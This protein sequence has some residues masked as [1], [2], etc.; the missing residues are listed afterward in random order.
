M[1]YIYLLC[2]CFVSVKTQ[3]NEIYYCDN[4]T[5]ILGALAPIHEGED[6]NEKGGNHVKCS[7]SIKEHAVPRVEAMLFAIDEINKDTNLLKDVKLGIHIVDTC[8]IPS[9]G[10]NRA[11]QFID[12]KCED[13]LRTEKAYVAGVVGAMYSSVSI[14]VA[15]FLTPWKLPQISPA[16]TSAKLED[17]Y[18]FPMF[19][20]T[21]PSDVHQNRVILDILKGLDW[22]LIS[23]IVSNEFTGEGLKKFKHR[24]HERGI[25]DFK[26][27]ELPVEHW[28]NKYLPGKDDTY[29]TKIICQILLHTD[30]NVVVFLTNDQDTI[31]ILKAKH[32]VQSGM[33]KISW[34][35]I[36]F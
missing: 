25:C 4:C 8:G 26:D 32:Q 18:G 19:A 16:S 17:K 2:L 22:T 28:T 5:I 33:P 14:D 34:Y 23:T 29:F 30:S 15:K 31:K 6:Y 13:N 36:R 3:N 9:I 35:I 10:T 12:I 7:H 11:K 21:V 20:R 27:F 1:L 24:A